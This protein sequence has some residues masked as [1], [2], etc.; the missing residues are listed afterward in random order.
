[1]AINALREVVV[2]KED[3]VYER[4]EITLSDGNTYKHCV[5]VDPETDEP[6]CII[7]WAIR[8][9]VP[10]V[11]FPRNDVWIMGATKPIPLDGAELTERAGYVFFAAQMLQDDLTHTWGQALKAA[12]K[13]Y[14][15]C[16]E[17]V[18]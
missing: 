17:E 2:G 7:G 1:M 16:C 5:Y 15:E 8:Q 3:Y 12:E 10:S 6:S 14:T 11:K 9:L 13:E 4:P 18:A